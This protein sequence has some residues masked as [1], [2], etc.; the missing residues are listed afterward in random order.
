M[1]V[2]V[3][4]DEAKKIEAFMRRA[5]EA[6]YTEDEIKASIERKYGRKPAPVDPK[7][8]D[9]TEGMSTTEK[10]LAGVGKAFVDA[11]RGVGQLA[12]D[13]AEGVGMDRP[14]WAPTQAD[15][16]EVRRRDAPLMN[17]GAGVTG[18]VLGN[19][20]TFA[21][22]ALIPGANTIAGGA[23]IGA[24]TG[25]A[26]PV[27]E[28]ESR[29]GNA[30][31]GGVAGGALPAAA[32]A[33]RVGKAALVDPFTEAGKQRIVGGT[34][35]RA[36]GDRERTLANLLQ[37]KAATP[38]VN[39][40]TGQASGDAGIASLERAASAVDPGGFQSIKD[41]QTAA[42][43]RALRGVAGSPEARQ[44]AIDAREQATEA[45]YAQAKKAAVPGDAELAALLQRPTVA[46][47]LKQ[48]Q[49]IAADEGRAFQLMKG[50]PASPVGVLD[51]QGN[52]IM[53]AATPDVYSG[54][55]LHDL[56]MG[57]DKALTE[58]SQGIG[59]RIAGSQLTAK[60]DFLN[61]LESRIPEYGQ[62]RTTFAELSKPINQMDV[63]EELYKRFVPALADNGA[64]PFKSR[65]DAYANAL[66]NG[67]QLARSVTGMKGAKLENIMTPEQM[68][69]LQGVASDLGVLKGAESAGRGVGSDTVQKM[70]MSHLMNQAGVPNWMQSIGRVPGGWLRTL[71]DVL[72]T[73]NDDALRATL[74]EVF[75]DPQ[76][77]A[78][79]MQMAK[80]DP[81]RFMQAMQTLGQGTALSLPAS[82]NAAE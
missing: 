18:N 38:G 78:Q 70:A 13:L 5:S 47:G 10:L 25:A 63:G 11:G 17:T 40:T 56:K 21:P 51:A 26:M 81:T 20:A 30:A 67:D 27:A 6:G 58:G 4:Q 31:I 46:A 76:A 80:T 14:S 61:W 60:S 64:V 69:S 59:N 82:V 42:L 50:K 79:A 34:L 15:I 66:R 62:A 45:L 28:G 49:G 39:L 22:L 55:G 36:A 65:A 57:I 72:Y 3:N 75:K 77:A 24:L 54:Q 33:Y 44:A 23:T 35:N 16:E 29:G 9:P 2:T 71:G 7:Q 32:R 8:F 52:P 41:D 37:R 53:G 12:G 1:N 43:V 48:A 19:I 74:A 68:A 73:K